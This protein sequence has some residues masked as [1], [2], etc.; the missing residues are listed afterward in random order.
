MQRYKHSQKIKDTSVHSGIC[1][2]IQIQKH[3]KVY[4]YIR[5]YHK[6]KSSI[7]N[8]TYPTTLKRKKSAMKK[9]AKIAAK[10]VLHV[11]INFFLFP[12]QSCLSPN[13]FFSYFSLPPPFRMN[14]RQNANPGFW[15][16]VKTMICVQEIATKRSF[17]FIENLSVLYEILEELLSLLCLVNDNIKDIQWYACREKIHG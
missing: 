7:D 9:E 11:K 16:E 2:C 13:I 15:Q 10:S 1:A 17:H 6:L 12:N 14:K 8:A 4:I 5:V 3:T